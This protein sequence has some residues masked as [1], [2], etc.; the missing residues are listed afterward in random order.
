VVVE[1]LSPSTLDDDR[2]PKMAFHKP[3]PSCRHIALV[4]RDEWRV[5]AWDR[6]GESWAYRVLNTTDAVLE[7]PAVE[8]AILLA[9]IYAGRRA[10]RPDPSGQTT[11]PAS[12][13]FRI[14]NTETS[15]WW[16]SIAR[17]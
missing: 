12:P 1:I 13:S 10:W 2:G 3:I 14:R 11:K 6:A 8:H 17:V 15:R 9:D 16:P 5:E 7:L 4:Y